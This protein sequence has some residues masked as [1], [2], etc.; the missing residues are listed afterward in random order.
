LV[1]AP[2]QQHLDRSTQQTYGDGGYDHG[3]PEKTRSTQFVSQP[4]SDIN[5]QHIKRTMGKVDD[6]GDAKDQ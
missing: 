5:A 1:N 2:Q 6:A 3:R 4:I